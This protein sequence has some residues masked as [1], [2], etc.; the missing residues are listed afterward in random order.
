MRDAFW[1]VGGEQAAGKASGRPALCA[2]NQRASSNRLKGCS[3]AG[4]HRKPYDLL[5]KTAVDGASCK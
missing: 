1:Q 4:G 5:L 2:F 3:A